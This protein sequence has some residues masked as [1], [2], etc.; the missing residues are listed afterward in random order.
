M[1]CVRNLSHQIGNS[2]I[3]ND[4]SVDIP[5]GKVTALVGPNGAGKSTLLSLI[6]RLE[7]RQNGQVTVGP[8][9]VGACSNRELAKYLSILPQMPD[10]VPRLTIREL[11]SFGRYPYHQGRPNPQDRQ[12]VDAALNVFGLAEFA[13]RPIAALSGGNDSERRSQ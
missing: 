13:N 12:K 6:A 10:Q 5:Q 11:V 3:L 7:K 1:I 8:L 2:L 4:I 9:T